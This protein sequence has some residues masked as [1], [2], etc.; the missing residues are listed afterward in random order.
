MERIWALRN[1]M[2]DAKMEG[3]GQKAHIAREAK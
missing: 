1:V 2:K 3:Q